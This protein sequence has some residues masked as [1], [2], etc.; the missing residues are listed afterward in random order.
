MLRKLREIEDL[1][2]QNLIL[3]FYFYFRIL[4]Q[5]FE[6]IQRF[7]HTARMAGM[8][9]P[10]NEL[11]LLQLQCQHEWQED[12]ARFRLQPGLLSRPDS[13][14]QRC[15]PQAKQTQFRPEAGD[16]SRELPGAARSG[17]LGAAVLASLLQC[18]HSSV[19]TTDFLTVYSDFFASSM[20]SLAAE[21]ARSVLYQRLFA[22]RFRFSMPFA[23]WSVINSRG[24][25]MC[26]HVQPECRFPI[27]RIVNKRITLWHLLLT[28]AINFY[29]IS[30]SCCL[31]FDVKFY[32]IKVCHLI[33]FDNI[34]GLHVCKHKTVK[35]KY[36]HFRCVIN[37]SFDS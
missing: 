27:E 24:R 28:K 31:M 1:I 8:G 34:C 11:S 22:N 13:Q 10:Y 33:R 20:L 3:Q 4:R 16:V 15:F 30:S 7:V 12:K 37:L 25:H 6:Q 21:R 18:H 32:W 17:G 29:L 14:R 26:T 2:V 36:I 35:I 19:S 23:H 5:I 9:R